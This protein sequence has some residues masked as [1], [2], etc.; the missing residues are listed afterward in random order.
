MM[1]FTRLLRHLSLVGTV[2][3]IFS[4]LFLVFSASTGTATFGNMAVTF[5]KSAASLD[6]LG[7]PSH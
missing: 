4:H 3:G 2:S 6:Q 7:Y 1:F 5:G